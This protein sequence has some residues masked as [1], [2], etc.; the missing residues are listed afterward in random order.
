MLRVSSWEAYRGI[1]PTLGRR[2]KEILKVIKVAPIPVTNNEI[3]SYLGWAINR[4]TPRVL[5]LRKMGLVIEYD[6]RRC[7]VVNSPVRVLT[8][9]INGKYYG[10]YRIV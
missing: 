10:Q 7:K 3:A 8:W 4:V 9:G 6:R 2:Q 1:K 5:E